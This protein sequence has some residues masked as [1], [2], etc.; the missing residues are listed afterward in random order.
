MKIE[1]LVGNEDVKFGH[2]TSLKVPT[3]AP[4]ELPGYTAVQISDRNT[5]Q[6]VDKIISSFHLTPC[7]QRLSLAQLVPG[8]D[9][10]ELVLLSAGEYA[11]RRAFSVLTGARSVELA[12]DRDAGR[13]GSQENYNR[14]CSQLP[15]VQLCCLC[16]VKK[17]PAR[18]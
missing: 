8:E 1:V 17:D 16:K 13:T 5:L 14:L 18:L 4:L 3:K 2:S 10:W 11:K 9:E 7:L 6:Q 12:D 15:Q